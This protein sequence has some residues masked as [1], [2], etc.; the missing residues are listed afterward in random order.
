[1]TDDPIAQLRERIRAT[2]DAAD[3]MATD[4]AEGRTPRTD[5]AAQETQ[6]LAAL[7]AM[8]RDALPEELRQQVLD[9]IRQVLLLVRAILDQV[10]ARLEAGP[11]APG[12]TGSDVQD[13]PVR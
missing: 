13:I 6:A 11:P 12:E 4:A 5:E 7:L 1:M 2:A 9:L 8:L 10:L 3:R